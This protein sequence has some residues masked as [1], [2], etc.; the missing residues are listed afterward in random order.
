MHRRLNSSGLESAHAA[1]KGFVR[2]LVPDCLVPRELKSASRSTE[3]F[4][5]EMREMSTQARGRERS[6]TLDSV[7]SCGGRTVRK[8]QRGKGEDGSVRRYRI[9]WES[10][11]ETEKRREERENRGKGRRGWWRWARSN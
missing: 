6:E 7:T 1:V 8:R 5:E 3:G 11:E 2:K 4:E 10:E 9:V